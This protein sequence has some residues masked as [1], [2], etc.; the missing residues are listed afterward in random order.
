MA[1]ELL[2]LIIPTFN[3]P[4]FLGRIL[5]YYQEQ[6]FQYPIILA[7][8]STPD[9][10][11]TN[12][13]IIASFGNGLSIHSERY[14]PDISLWLKMSRI[15]TTVDTKYV[16]PCADDDFIVP[17]VLKDCVRFLEANP[18]YS[19]AHGHQVRTF[20]QSKQGSNSPYT[21]HSLIKRQDTIAFEDPKRR[22][23][24]FLTH[25]PSTFY[26]VHRRTCFMR[27]LKLAYE[28]SFGDDLFRELL[29]CCLNAIQGKSIHF[30]VFYMVHQIHAPMSA[31]QSK[32]MTWDK[33]RGLDDFS[34]RYKQFCNCLAGTLA[35]VTGISKTEAQGVARR[36]FA[37]YLRPVFRRQDKSGSGKSMERTQSSIPIA[38]GIIQKLPVA[39]TSSLFSRG[40]ITMLR[41]LCTAYHRITSKPYPLDGQDDLSIGSLLHPLSPFRKDFL[42]IYRLLR[43]YPYGCP[44]H[45]NS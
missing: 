33:M 35:T 21:L 16:V 15:V 7:D 40:L 23:H 14:P 29:V 31:E 5:R 3:R 42:P 9:F 20:F 18:D 6:Q 30:N 26:S 25:P 1:K 32:R 41:T 45:K 36:A 44:W 19:L 4:H 39:L 2:S 38:P 24:Y 8:S 28:N 37:A 27:S 22:L 13:E 12:Q 34:Q 43:D 10:R 17:R 11:N